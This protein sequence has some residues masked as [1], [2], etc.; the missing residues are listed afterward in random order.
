MGTS[1]AVELDTPSIL[2]RKKESG[3]LCRLM[4]DIEI[5]SSWGLRIVK[6]LVADPRV[7]NT[8]SNRR[9]SVENDSRSD[10]LVVKVW[11]SQEVRRHSRPIKNK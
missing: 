9:V 1:D 10:G 6:N 8:V 4:S 5:H 11:S 2:S 7:V 3:P